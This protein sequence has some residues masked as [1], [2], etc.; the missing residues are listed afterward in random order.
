MMDAI[1]IPML[2]CLSLTATDCDAITIPGN[3]RY[4]TVEKCH[5]AIAKK[6]QLENERW[7]CVNPLRAAE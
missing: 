4:A 6:A 1:F 3:E 5:E 2:V 7:I